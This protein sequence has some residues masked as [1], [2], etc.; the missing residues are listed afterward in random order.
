MVSVRELCGVLM[1]NKY[2]QAL[3]ELR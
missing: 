1:S 3:A 2:C